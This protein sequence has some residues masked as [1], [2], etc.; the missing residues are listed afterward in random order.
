M[1]TITGTLIVIKPTQIVSDKFSKREFVVVTPEKYP[2]SIQLEL[3]GQNCDII[4]SYKEGQQVI[5]DINIRGRLWTSPQGEDKYF[6]TLV[7]WKI[8]PVSSENA[9]EFQTPKPT[10]KP[11]NSFVDEPKEFKNEKEDDLPF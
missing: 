9:T 3:Q 10:S 4:D 8:Q 5:C 1:S 2:Q 11:Y 6:N 7:A